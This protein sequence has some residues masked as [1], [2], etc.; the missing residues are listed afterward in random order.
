VPLQLL[1]LGIQARQNAKNVRHPD[2]RRSFPDKTQPSCAIV[3]RP[4]EI[5]AAKVAALDMWAIKMEK[6]STP[7]WVWLSV[8][9]L[10]IGAATYVT[11]VYF[12]ENILTFFQRPR[13]G[14]H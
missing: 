6:E 13:D 3:A 8:A 4:G 10:V 7:L 2:A 1:A 5:S 11:T 9:L 12:I 14:Q